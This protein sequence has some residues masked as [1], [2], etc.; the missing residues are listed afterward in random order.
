VTSQLAERVRA[1]GEAW[2]RE[3]ARCAPHHRS[4]TGRVSGVSSTDVLDG[5]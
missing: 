1:A 4:I 3:V 2:V 5:A